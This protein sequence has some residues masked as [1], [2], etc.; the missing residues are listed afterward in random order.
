MATVKTTLGT[1]WTVVGVTPAVLQPLGQSVIFVAL[2][3]SAPT[4][5]DADALLVNPDDGAPPFVDF[6]STRV[7]TGQNIYARTPSGPAAVVVAS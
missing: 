5:P 7:A 1:S 4:S 2:G 3:S 6:A